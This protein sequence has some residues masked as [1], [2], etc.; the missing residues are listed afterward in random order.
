MAIYKGYKKISKIFVGSKE[1]KKVYKGTQLVYGGEPVL[2]PA[3]NCAEL[4]TMFKGDTTL[5]ETPVINATGCTSLSEVFRGCTNL[6]TVKYIHIPNVTTTGSAFRGCSS[7]T[8]I[9]TLDTSNVINMA[10]MFDGCSLLTSVTFTGGVVPPY[11]SNMFRGTPIAAGS[12]FIF[13]PDEM[14]DAYKV[15]Y[16][17]SNYASVIRGISEK[18]YITV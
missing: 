16:G 12:G 4:L 17:W 13:V 11:G 6:K 18:G 10:Y 8:S 5:T 2:P 3:V 9:P 14:V 7:L 1:I 15:A